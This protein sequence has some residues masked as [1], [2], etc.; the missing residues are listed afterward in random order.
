MKNF[1]ENFHSK[2]WSWMLRSLILPFGDLVFR[3][4]MINR[5]KFL[6]KAQWWDWEQIEKYRNDNLKKLVT[7]AY[8]EVLFYRNLFD[9]IKV[10]PDDINTPDDLRKLPVVTKDMLRKYFPDGT[11]R[12]TGRKTHK[13]CTSGSTGENF[14]VIEDLPTMAWYR[15][16]NLLALEWA[17]WNIGESHLQ[18]GINLNRSFDRKIKDFLLK[19]YYISAYNLSDENLDK[20]LIIL[21]KYKIK[22]LWG[23]P[24]SLYYLA[25]RAKQKGWNIPLKTIVTWGDNLYKHYRDTIESAFKQKVIDTYGCSEGMQISAQCGYDNLY[26]IH[27]L[28]V[29]VEY[30]DEK[31]NPVPEGE[32]GSI[33]VTRLYPGPMPLIRYKVGDVGISGKSIK[34]KCGRGFEVMKSIQGRETDIILTPSGNRLIVHF[35]T[36]ILENFKEISQYQVV[37][38]TL[39]YFTI[40]IVP[41]VNF[42]EV[43]KKQ[44]IDIMRKRG[45]EDIN[46]KFEIVDEIPIL[47][48]GKRR[49]VISNLKK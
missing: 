24:G 47:P 34:C 35:F 5:L 2:L 44:I 29:I 31:G 26:H 48:S 18:T 15:A 37:Q 45:G 39:E 8:N 25:K 9:S 27:S 28:D 12:N 19:C 33:V 14:C 6:E 11:V 41:A 32:T 4:N 22:H 7:I 38:D 21:E 40:K 13:V 17:G 36:G 10:K 30:L 43:T 49:F 3:Q 23:Y 16:S 20:A 42:T 46:I 1:I